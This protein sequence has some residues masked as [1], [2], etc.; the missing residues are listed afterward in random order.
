MA[1]VYNFSAGPA[2]LPH[3]VLA[4]AQSEML[5]W[6]GSGMCVM[7]MSHRGKEFMEIIHDAEHDLRELM[8]IPKNYKVLFLQ[9]G[10]SLQFAM[11]PL[12]LLGDKKSIDVVNTGHWSKLAIKEAKRYANVNVVASSEDRNFT[13]VPAEETWQRDPDAAYLHYTSNETIGGL[14]FP[15]I[16]SS[17]NGVPLVCDM[18]SDFLSREVDVSQFGLI[19]AGAQKNIGPSGLT[20][21]IV[22]EDLLGKAL[23]STPTMLNYQVH[24]DADSMYNTPATYPIYIAGLVFKWLKEL[25]GIKGMAARNDEKAGLL[26]HA[27]ESSNGFY[28]ST[29]DAPFRSKMNVVFRLKDESLEDTFLSEAKKNGL[30]QLKGHRAV[31]GMR[32]SIYNAMPIEGVKALVSFMMDFARQHSS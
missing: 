28:Y 31:G 14:Q 32:A 1:K 6:H 26:Y 27:I 29:V 19:Y 11:L 30:V 9:G 22:R 23:P 13:Y 2:V 24:A 3:A 16:P 18:S 15:F 12:N 25:G 8:Q 17:A 4:E 10:A 21:V 7:E 20:V 5:D